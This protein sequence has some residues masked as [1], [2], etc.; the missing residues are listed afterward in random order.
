MNWFE[1]MI[2]DWKDIK[3]FFKGRWFVPYF[4]VVIIFL[5]GAFY[6]SHHYPASPF[7]RTERELEVKA[8]LEQEMQSLE[9]IPGVT[10]SQMSSMGGRDS[11]NHWT[12]R[13]RVAASEIDFFAFQRHYSEQLKLNGWQELNSGSRYSKYKKGVY[14]AEI[15]KEYN[16]DGYAIYL[17]WNW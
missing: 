4:S 8:E 5:G 11:H 16:P 15:L 12:V 17:N 7:Q 6:Y 14:E 10:Y 3:S 13:K 2:P 1:M 9:P